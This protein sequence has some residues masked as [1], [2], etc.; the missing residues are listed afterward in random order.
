MIPRCGAVPGVELFALST[1]W[2]D[3]VANRRDAV[4]GK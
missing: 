1:Y 4:K 2:A 3:A